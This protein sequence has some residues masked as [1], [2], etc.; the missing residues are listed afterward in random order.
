MFLINS[1]PGVRCDI[2]GRAV[3]ELEPFDDPPYEMNVVDTARECVLFTTADRKLAKTFRGEGES[4]ASWECQ[5]CFFLTNDEAVGRKR[6][7]ERKEGLI[8]A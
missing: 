8:D 2:C 4:R 6:Q 1:P 7:R 3:S 5:D